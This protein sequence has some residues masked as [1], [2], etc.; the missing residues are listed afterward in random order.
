[1]G[2][3]EAKAIRS[4]PGPLLHRLASEHFTQC[5]M[6]QVRARMI[7]HRGRTQV[8]IDNGFHLGIDADL[9]LGHATHMHEQL[10]MG[11][12]G[13][14]NRNSA[15]R[16]DQ[17]PLITHLTAAFGIEGRLVEN[18]FDFVTLSST[19]NRLS[20]RQESDDLRIAPGRVVAKKFSA[21]HSGQLPVDLRDPRVSTTRPS[22][23]RPLTLNLHGL[24]EAILVDFHIVRAENIRGQ[25]QR[26]PERVV[27]PECCL[28]IQC[29][30]ALGFRFLN[31]FFQHLQTLGKSRK[32]PLFI[33][34][35]SVQDELA[36]IPKVWVG[37]SQFVDRCVG[38][39]VEKRL[40]EAE[41][42]PVT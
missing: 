8:A 27:E 21:V 19:F 23:P 6:E 20:I 42:N 16:R 3:I 31:F 1:M 15:C 10:V 25:I 14:T 40:F 35:D 9:A 39:L 2:E 33:S 5:R 32:K 18:H 13:I 41:Q 30:N 34:L 38:H 11:F 24:V 29:R 17:T 12:L 22:S 28:T 37:F 4:H 7:S 36:P 26:E